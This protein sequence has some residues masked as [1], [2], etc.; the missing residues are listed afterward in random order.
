MVAK[1]YIES[2]LKK[3]TESVSLFEKEAMNCNNKNIIEYSERASNYIAN[4]RDQHYA[5]DY[6]EK[7]DFEDINRRYLKAKDRFQR[8]CNCSF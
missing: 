3:L 5:L 4:F 8:T 7:H 6:I 1:K 2:G